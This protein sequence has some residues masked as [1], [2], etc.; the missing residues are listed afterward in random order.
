MQ[1]FWAGL[2]RRDRSSFGLVRRDW[3]LRCKSS[4]RR[5]RFAA[6]LRPKLG[7]ECFWVNAV[8][9]V[10]VCSCWGK[11]VLGTLRQFRRKGAQV[12]GVL[13]LALSGIVA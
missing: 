2:R 13:V 10:G 5:A 3:V 7:V 6:L 9:G 11:A 12:Q 4:A 8:G 1:I